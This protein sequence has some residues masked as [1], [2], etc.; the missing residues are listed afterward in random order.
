MGLAL[1]ELEGC[2]DHV[3][4]TNDVKILL[5][6]RIKDYIDNGPPVSVDY[7]ETPYGSGFVID[8]GSSC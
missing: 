5:D 6:S 2:Q 3:I 1:D 7:R 4:D 8:G